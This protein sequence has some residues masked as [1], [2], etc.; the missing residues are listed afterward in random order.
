MFIKF[1]HSGLSYVRQGRLT[2]QDQRPD[3]RRIDRR[4][5]QEQPRILQSQSVFETDITCDAC[6]CHCDYGQ[7]KSKYK[8]KSVRFSV[9]E[10]G[11]VKIMYRKE[12]QGKAGEST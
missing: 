7:A 9:E 4:V 2:E 11:R 10:M 1:R 8:Y 5:R 6:G 12:V 3:P